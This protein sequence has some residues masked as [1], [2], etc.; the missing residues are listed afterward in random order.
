VKAREAYS[1]EEYAAEL[2]AWAKD[3]KDEYAAITVSGNSAIVP[4]SVS[5]PI[6]PVTYNPF[7][8][9]YSK[10]G[11]TPESFGN[12]A[13][14]VMPVITST[15]GGLIPEGTL[16]TP[17]DASP[18]VGTIAL[19]A[20]GY[21]SKT[22]WYSNE[23]INSESWDVTSSTLPALQGAREYGFAK[24]IVA[25]V[26]ADSTSTF[27]TAVTTA[28]HNTV[29]IDNLDD[30]IHSFTLPY[31][32]NKAVFLGLDLW[33]AC[34]KLKDSNGR[35][36]FEM[37][38]I[39]DQSFTSYKGV[40]VFKF[41]SFD[42]FTTAGNFVGM[43]VSFTGFKLRDELEKLIKYVDQSNYVDM[44]GLNDVKYQGYGY[45]GLAVTKFNCGT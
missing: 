30:L 6:T 42:A 12:T 8:A 31:D 44:T 26:K 1:R 17:N 15:S 19:S 7:R 10:L 22:Y 35:P 24:A 23:L 39:Q 4:Q 27:N 9:A 21:Q 18:A 25:A 16:N 32:N 36:I 29:T 38:T 5:K 2:S 28:T 20:N 14:V 37:F 43:A 11:L 33:N 13:P 3:E 41:D 40:P 34:E 45:I